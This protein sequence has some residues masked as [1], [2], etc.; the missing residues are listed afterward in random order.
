MIIPFVQSLEVLNEF[1]VSHI[2][3]EGTHV[4]CRSELGKVLLTVNLDVI[5]FRVKV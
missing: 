4:P 5:S 2:P 1:W 3:F